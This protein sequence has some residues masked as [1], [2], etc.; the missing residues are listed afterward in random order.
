MPC[1]FA[2]GIAG[3]PPKAGLGAPCER[4]NHIAA[5]P[6]KLGQSCDNVGQ[7]HRHSLPSLAHAS[8]NQT[9]LSRQLGPARREVWKARSVRVEQ[10]DQL[11]EV[12][13]RSRQ[14]VHLVDD[15][16]VD[17]AGLNILQQFLERRP[18][19]LELC[20]LLTEFFGHALDLSSVFRRFMWRRSAFL[21]KAEA[22]KA[23]NNGEAWS[24]RAA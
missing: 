9:A 7:T 4:R 5:A 23:R 15:D 21:R 6:T 24:S 22:S 19:H 16:H 14:P 11:G 2:G 20:G 3:L 10:L 1:G 8:E 17:L 12:G 18:L 13:E